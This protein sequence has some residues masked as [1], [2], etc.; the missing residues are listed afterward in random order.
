VRR[1]LLGFGAKV[2]VLGDRV[3]QLDD[4]RRQARLVLRRR[5]AKRVE[6]ERQGALLV[7]TS[8]REWFAPSPDPIRS[9][10][11]ASREWTLLVDLGSLERRCRVGPGS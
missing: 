11:G 1:R 7:L 2:E 10:S 5:Q 3:L 4:G 9:A 6:H 8:F